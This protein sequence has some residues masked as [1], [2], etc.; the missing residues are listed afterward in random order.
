[1]MIII[2]CVVFRVW[3]QLKRRSSCQVLSTETKQRLGVSRELNH[4]AFQAIR[5]EQVTY[6][7]DTS[8]VS[9]LAKILYLLLFYSH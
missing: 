3:E 7:I 8:S 2:I 5:I 1:M 9:V 4:P 6:H